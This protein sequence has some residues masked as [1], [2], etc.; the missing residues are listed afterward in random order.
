MTHPEPGHQA[1]PASPYFE[2]QDQAPDGLPPGPG[3]PEPDD[4]WHHAPHDPGAWDSPEPPAPD[5]DPGWGTYIPQP[6]PAFQ[7]A[8]TPQHPA[9]FPPAARRLSRPRGRT[10]VI[11]GLVVLALAGT[12]AA[13]ATGALR[14]SPGKPAA[15]TR[16]SPRGRIHAGHTT[17]PAQHPP[18]VPAPMITRAQAHTVLSHY[19]QVNNAAN[20]AYNAAEL[21]TVEGGSSYVMDAGGYRFER[22]SPHK[23]PYSPFTLT[24]PTYY[25]PRQTGTGYPRWFA[26]TGTTVPVRGGKPLGDMYI[27]FAR[28]KANAPWKNV[29]EPYVIPARTPTPAIALDS[30]GYATAISPGTSAPPLEVPADQI[31]QVTAGSLNHLATLSDALITANASNLTDLHDEVFWRS[32]HGGARITVTDEHTTTLFAVFGLRTDGGGAILFYTLKAQLRLTAP[33]GTTISHLTIPGYYHLTGHS[34]LTSVT[35][36]YIEQICTYMPSAGQHG[37]HIVADTA[38]IAFRG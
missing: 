11:S 16:T 26:V 17:A 13:F 15:L 14:L 20:A 30:A 8:A 28:A 5:G 12:G 24:A 7:A 19:L 29:N 36:G 38:S 18:A 4:E 3:Q 35:I 2:D 31:A 27:V 22:N 21:H 9:A 6:P 25:I 10:L 23:T 33:H 1:D 34:K 37:S 32:G